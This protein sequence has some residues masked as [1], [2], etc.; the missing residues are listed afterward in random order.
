VTSQKK[1]KERQY[2]KGI[3]GQRPVKGW[4]KKREEEK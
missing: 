3:M 4:P 1:K 2:E